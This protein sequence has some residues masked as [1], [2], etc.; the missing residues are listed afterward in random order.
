MDLPTTRVWNRIFC[1][2]LSE[3]PEVM[4]FVKDVAISVGFAQE[5][6]N[7]IQISLEEVF[8]N[9]VSYAYSKETN[10]NAI[11]NCHYYSDGTLELVLS[12]RGFA[13]DPLSVQR[14][15]IQASAEERKIGG[16]GVF[17]AQKLM[18]EMH[19]RREQDRNI[20]TL[21][22]QNRKAQNQ[23]PTDPSLS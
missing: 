17:F 13:Y 18:D 20:L 22:K 23:L 8:V 11:L 3:L 12:D 16:L 7:Q 19:Y 6:V 5:E 9:I 21:R 10:G 15:D 14:A 4:Q 1:A 2:S